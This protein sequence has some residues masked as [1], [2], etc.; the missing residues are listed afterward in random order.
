MAKK[1][2]PRPT[3]KVWEWQYADG[4]P[5][6]VLYGPGVAPWEDRW[7]ARANDLSRVGRWLRRLKKPPALSWDHL[8]NVPTFYA[9]AKNLAAVRSRMIVDEAGGERPSWFL[10][11]CPGRP[12]APRLSARP[13]LRIAPD[14]SVVR[15][16]SIYAAARAEGV[17]WTTIDWRI[18]T[19]CADCNGCRWCDDFAG[20]LS[21]RG[22]EP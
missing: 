16:G 13:V 5:A 14:G 3:F 11:G 20:C 18:H 7:A 22:L 4:R 12:D 8:P 10:A 21:G 1:R 6:A 15:Y 9:E 2:G 19:S 17:D